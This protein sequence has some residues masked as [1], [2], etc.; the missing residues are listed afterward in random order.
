MIIRRRME[1]R[2]KQGA[3]NTIMRIDG[4]S[5]GW[6][7]SSWWLR[8]WWWWIWWSGWKPHSFIRYSFSFSHGEET[9]H[10]ELWLRPPPVHSIPSALVPKPPL[11]PSPKYTVSKYPWLAYHNC[12]RDTFIDWWSSAVLTSTHWMTEHSV[13]A[14]QAYHPSP[15]VGVKFQMWR[16]LHSTEQNRTWRL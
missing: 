8:W 14:E 3:T 9:T 5:H 7:G 4:T 10:Q 6:W 1:M 16:N 11:I 12:R 15:W 2:R 13:G